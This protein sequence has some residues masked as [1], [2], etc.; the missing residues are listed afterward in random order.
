MPSSQAVDEIL[1]GL[2]LCGSNMRN[3]GEIR[4]SLRRKESLREIS[5]ADHM[6]NQVEELKGN[7]AL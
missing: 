1:V 5:I 6:L 2:S 7:T 3:N 4:E